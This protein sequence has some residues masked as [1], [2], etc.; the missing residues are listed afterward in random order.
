MVRFVIIKGGNVGE[1]SFLEPKHMA[2]PQSI[3]EPL[4]DLLESTLPSLM[5][6]PSSF[7]LSA[8]YVDVGDLEHTSSHHY[9]L[10]LLF[11]VAFRSLQ[12]FMEIGRAHV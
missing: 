2:L 6:L 10:L 9:L 12:P 4:V 8:F 3:I 1:R 5:V 7:V 11:L